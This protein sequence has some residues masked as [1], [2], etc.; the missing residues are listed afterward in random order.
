M[1]TTFAIELF[2]RGFPVIVVPLSVTTVKGCP[3]MVTVDT[4]EVGPA[5]VMGVRPERRSR[6]GLTVAMG[7]S[8][9]IGKVP[10]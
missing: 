1:T 7:G 6:D 10:P 9:H 4:G 3:T 2:G 5:M 8:S